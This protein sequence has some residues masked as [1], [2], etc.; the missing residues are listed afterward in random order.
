MKLYIPGTHDLLRVNYTSV[1]SL[2]FQSARKRMLHYNNKRIYAIGWQRQDWGNYV[3]DKAVTR[4]AVFNFPHLQIDWFSDKRT[5]SQECGS[6]ARKTSYVL[7]MWYA[8][9][10]FLGIFF[11]Q[12]Q[13]WRTQNH[14]LLIILSMTYKEIH[15]QF[16]IYIKKS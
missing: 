15:L 6:I 5:P 9:V 7:R 8:L 1:Y 12:P 4:K 2:Y 3:A 13:K 11:R 16:D 14:I 10:R